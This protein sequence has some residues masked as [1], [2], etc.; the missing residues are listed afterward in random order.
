MT[1]APNDAASRIDDATNR[2]RKAVEDIA[3][4]EAWAKRDRDVRD[5]AL[6]DLKTAGLTVP[7]IAEA[8]G[9]N[10]HTIRLALR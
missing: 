5:D 3:T 2:A 9:I 4:A 7:A 8:T 10:I 6:R 1:K